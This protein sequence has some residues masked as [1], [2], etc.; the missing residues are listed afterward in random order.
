MITTWDVRTA[1]KNLDI[2]LVPF[3]DELD[4]DEVRGAS[5]QR[6][7]SIRPGEPHPIFISLHEFAHVVLG[8]TKEL[9]QRHYFMPATLVAIGEIEAHTVALALAKDLELIDGIDYDEA[10]ERH[11]LLHAGDHDD[12]AIA[13]YIQ[14][15]RPKLAEAALKIYWAGTTRSAA[16]RLSGDTVAA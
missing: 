2:T 4:P 12:R 9:E 15:V 7:V 10:E 11:Y 1:A 16:G 14:S 3:P 6:N 8:H 13:R 5:E